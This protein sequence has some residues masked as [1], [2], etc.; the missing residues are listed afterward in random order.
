MMSRYGSAGLTMTMSA[1]SSRSA[2]ISRSASSRVA[3]IHLVAAPV[4]ELRRRL[5][6]LAERAVE[7]RAVLGRVGHDRH[8]AR[9]PSS[10]S[11]ARMRA[12]APVHHV[13]RRD[14]VG[15]G[16]GVR[17]APRP[18]A[19]RASRRCRPPSPSRMPQCPWSVYSHRQTSV[20]T[21]RSGAAFLIARTSSL[22]D[23]VVE[24]RRPSRVASLCSGHAEQQH[25][26]NAEVA[27]ARGGLDGAVD[28][29]LGDAGHR[30]HF[31]LDAAAGHD[32]QR[33]D[34]IVARR[35]ASRAPCGGSFRCA[36]GGAVGS[37]GMPRRDARRSRCRFAKKSSIAS[38][39]ASI[40]YCCG[41]HV[42]PD[43]EAGE[44]LRGDRADGSD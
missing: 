2:A 8:V 21:Q 5:G 15:A 1:P 10:S 3:G 35:A 31:A 34:E 43:A 16:A 40:V 41:H 9:S 42:H 37:R 6:R 44:R 27:R 13:R 24:R 26:R 33:Q 36:A 17:D 20:I 39:S 22:H 38:A 19:A 32:E 30:R 14:D 28:G 18:R 23:A 25:G 29:Q 4:A 11:A 7:A 12:D